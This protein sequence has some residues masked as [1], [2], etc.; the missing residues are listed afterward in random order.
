MPVLHNTIT[1]R[2]ISQS[3]LVLDCEDSKLFLLIGGRELCAAIQDDIVGNN[4][5]GYPVVLKGHQSG[6]AIGYQVAW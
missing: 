6:T 4:K 2:V 1:V 5:S 3:S